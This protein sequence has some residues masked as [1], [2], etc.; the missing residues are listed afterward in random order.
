MAGGENTHNCETQVPLVQEL[1]LASN[2]EILLGVTR[3]ST[4]EH[5]SVSLYSIKEL[6]LHYYISHSR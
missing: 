4:L 5:S 3:M 6:L 1:H 2:I